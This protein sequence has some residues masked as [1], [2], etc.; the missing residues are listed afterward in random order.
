[1]E[2]KAAYTIPGYY[3]KPKAREAVTTLLERDHARVHYSREIS[4]GEW[5]ELS[6]HTLDTFI[7]PEFAVT[8]VYG[9]MWPKGDLQ[10][11]R[12][13]ITT[14]M[15]EGVQLTLSATSAPRL[16]DIHQR[17]M[18]IL[19]TCIPSPELLWGREQKFHLFTSMEQLVKAYETKSLD[20]IPSIL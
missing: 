9:G 17:V 12:D 11:H 6:F 13:D 14:M 5:D 15:Y 16:E 8:L 3:L 18:G 7:N 1:M 20:G 4:G 2:F 19:D 10:A